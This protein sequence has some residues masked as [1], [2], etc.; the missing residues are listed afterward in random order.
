MA[1]FAVRREIADVAKGT[2]SLDLSRTILW[3]AGERID[4]T[5]ARLGWTIKF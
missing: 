4:L 3:D 2:L 1:V 5:G